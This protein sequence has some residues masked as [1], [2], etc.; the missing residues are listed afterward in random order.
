MINYIVT[1]EVEDYKLMPLKSEYI[2]CG[3]VLIWLI[4]EN[5]TLR[6][7][8]MEKIKDFYKLKI[9]AFTE[10]IFHK[11]LCYI[12][13]DLFSHSKWVLIGIL[14][15][16]PVWDIRCL[17]NLTNTKDAYKTLDPLEFPGIYPKMK[18]YKR[19][20]GYDDEKQFWKMGVSYKL[21][22]MN[23]V[24]VYVGD[25]TKSKMIH[26]EIDVYWFKNNMRY[27]KSLED[28][29]KMENTV[30]KG[31][32][33]KIYFACNQLLNEHIPE[34]VKKKVNSKKNIN[35]KFNLMTEYLFVYCVWTG[36]KFYNIIAKIQEKELEAVNHKFKWDEFS[37]LQKALVNPEFD[38]TEDKLLGKRKQRDYD[39]EP[40]IFK[41]DK[42]KNGN[43]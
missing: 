31:S 30:D 23:N 11:D 21:C 28:Y 29:K 41:V 18:F 35:M 32:G 19:N 43:A 5:E 10:N 1:P 2:N 20:K 6:K 38:I 22:W 8:Y 3:R 27:F 15:R 25:Y 14:R 37:N 17:F 33:T 39:V 26:E 16:I 4:I 34:E 9:F 36:F 40:K 7:K 24:I 12:F 13:T 42:R